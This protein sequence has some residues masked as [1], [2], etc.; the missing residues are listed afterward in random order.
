MHPPV[1]RAGA[2][3]DVFGDRCQV[4]LLV[5]GETALVAREDQERADE[6]LGVI[7][8]G[9]DVRRHAAPSGDG[10]SN[11]ARRSRRQSLQVMKFP[12]GN[13]NSHASS[14]S[15]PSLRQIAFDGAL[16]TWGKACMKRCL[17]SRLASSIACAVAATALAIER[18]RA[19]GK[20]R[21][22]HAY[23]SVENAPS[24]AICRKLGFELM[25]ECDFEF[26]PGNQL[27]CND[28]RLDLF[29]PD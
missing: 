16:S 12:F 14:S 4:D 10:G 29:G 23:P 22:L 13:S 21:F 1:A 18:A 15:K 19:D 6:V 9:A 8:R 25:E 28:W 11:E 20:H 24:N 2:V 27:R 7:D 17:S 5:D 3:E 26:P